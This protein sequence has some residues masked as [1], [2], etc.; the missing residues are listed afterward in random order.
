MKYLSLS[1]SLSLKSL[2]LFYAR[3]NI[4]RKLLHVLFENAFIA[5]ALADP[6]STRPSTLVWSREQARR[7]RAR[8]VDNFRTIQPARRER[9]QCP[10]VRS[11]VCRLS[12]GHRAR[13]A[14]NGAAFV[15]FERAEFRLEIS[16]RR[17]L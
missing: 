10:T 16:Y 14:Y 5:H 6:Y 9:A 1:L 12:V 3:K 13:R 15:L 7:P 11:V 2:A 17:K 4:P 8:D